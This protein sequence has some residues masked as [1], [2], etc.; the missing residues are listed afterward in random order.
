MLSITIN[1][2]T[3]SMY[4]KGYDV[5]IDTVHDDS[6]NYTAMSGKKVSPVLGV[7]RV[8]TVRFEP[9][10]NTQIQTLFSA[11]STT[12]ANTI[13][14]QDPM[15]GEITKSFLCETLPAASYFESDEGVLFWTIPDITFTEDVDFSSAWESG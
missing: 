14:Y 8:L 12:T 1:N 7:Q 6:L 4:L 15:S 5:S 2:Q 9:M 13:T 10:S 3:I 11:I